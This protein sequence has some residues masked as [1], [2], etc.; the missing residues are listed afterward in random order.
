MLLILEEQDYNFSV[1]GDLATTGFIG[2]KN[3]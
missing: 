1:N 3:V 2:S